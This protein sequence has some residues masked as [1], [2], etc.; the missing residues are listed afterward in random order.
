MLIG[1]L[2]NL[3]VRC[4][5]SFL[6]ENVYIKMFMAVKGHPTIDKDDII[7]T[8]FAA[9]KKINADETG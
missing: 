2:R 1:V 6:F 9:Y 5:R 3:L 8:N 7:T 4:D